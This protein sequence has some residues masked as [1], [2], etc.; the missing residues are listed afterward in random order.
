M[1]Y[2]A[3]HKPDLIE[4][5]S[6]KKYLNSVIDFIDFLILENIKIYGLTLDALQKTKLR[7]QLWRKKQG[8]AER[9]QKHIKAHA[10]SEMMVY[11][12]T[13]QVKSYENC[14]VAEEAKTVFAMF[15]ANENA[16]LGR[17][18]YCL[19]RDHLYSLIHFSTSHLSDVTANMQR[20]MSMENGS[21]KFGTTKQ[22]ITMV[23]RQ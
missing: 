23:R 22:W 8:R 4:A 20:R 9:L 2:C 17:T 5:G 12:T 13:E 18:M 14:K 1:G 6:I 19:M 21:S 10:D 3:N 7:I 15:Q 16:K 11:A